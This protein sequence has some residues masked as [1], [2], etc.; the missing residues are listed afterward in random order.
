MMNSISFSSVGIDLL[1]FC[2]EPQVQ[3][4]KQIML[5]RFHSASGFGLS[6]ANLLHS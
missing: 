6:L 2:C 1:G 5:R 4:R 3:I